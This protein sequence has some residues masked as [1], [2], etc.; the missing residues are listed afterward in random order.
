MQTKFDLAAD[1]PA[2][3]DYQPARLGPADCVVQPEVGGRYRVVFDDKRGQN[4]YN[5]ACY[6]VAEANPHFVVLH[7]TDYRFPRTEVV[8]LSL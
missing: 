8:F 1:E 4:V 5:R 3:P 7:G 2:D 6:Y